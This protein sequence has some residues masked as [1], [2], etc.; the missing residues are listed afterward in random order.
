MGEWNAK[1]IFARIIWPFYRSVYKSKKAKKREREKRRG[2][3]QLLRSNEK[4]LNYVIKLLESTKH[5]QFL[6]LIDF[7]SRLTELRDI[8]HGH[9]LS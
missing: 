6:T 1:D 4:Q 8:G 7:S 9:F 2:F 5:E 3:M